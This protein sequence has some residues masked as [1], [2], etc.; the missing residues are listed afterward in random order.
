MEPIP[1]RPKACNSTPRVLKQSSSE[2]I[3]S[4]GIK[5]YNTSNRSDALQTAIRSCCWEEAAYLHQTD[6]NWRYADLEPVD[7][8]GI[9]YLRSLEE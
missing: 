8:Q 3:E 4:Q 1:F 5:K 7:M 6:L 2:E 9:D